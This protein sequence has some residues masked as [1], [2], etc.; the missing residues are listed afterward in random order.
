MGKKGCDD[1]FTEA[2]E[3]LKESKLVGNALRKEKNKAV[4]RLN[5]M[6]DVTEAPA[7]LRSALSLALKRQ[8]DSR[9]HFAQKAIEFAE[10]ALQDH[11][12]GLSMQI[13][14]LEAKTSDLISEIASVNTAVQ[15]AEERLAS[16]QNDSISADNEWV[17]EER[18][19]DSATKACEKLQVK[20][21]DIIEALAASKASLASVLELNTKVTAL[22]DHSN[23][24]AAAASDEKE[25]PQ[26]DV[27]PIVAET[28]EQPASALAATLVVA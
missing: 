1:V 19:V 26:T 13:E 21:D 18:A 17:T 20:S 7:S 25:E 15:A 10:A 9:T 24:T 23:S 22:R 4:S 28:V 16:A 5:A 2:W 8:A 3:P 6:I 12:A 14:T 11:T 27:V